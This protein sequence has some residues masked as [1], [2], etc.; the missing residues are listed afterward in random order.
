[1]ARINKLSKAIA[2]ILSGV[3]LFTGCAQRNDSSSIEASQ[4]PTSDNIIQTLP[5]LYNW[6]DVEFQYDSFSDQAFLSHIEDLVYAETVTSLNSEQ[7]FIENVSAIYI[8]KEYL[9]EV[10]YNSQSNIYFG[11]TLSELNE[12]F[13]GT[14]YIYTLDEDGTTT[15][16]EMVVVDSNVTGEILQNVAVGTGVILICITI[17]V[18]A[19]ALKADA[20][21][22]IFAAGA[23]D[24]ILDATFGSITA[25]IVKGIENGNVIS[26]LTAASEGFKI[27]AI[28]GTLEGTSLKALG[29]F[30]ASLG[31]LTMNEAARIQRESGY[32]LDV[33]KQLNNY[34]QYD[35][36]R[37]AGLTPKMVNGQTALVRSIDLNYVDKDGITNL[38]RMLSGRA[39]IDPATGKPYELHHIGQEVDSTLA[40]L[41]E[42]E[43][44]QNGNYTIWHNTDISS[45]VHT[46]DNNWDAQR[47]LFW[48]SLAKIMGG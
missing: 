7:Y 26:G 5:D 47:K 28:S 29:L 2:I 19:S 13:K 32:P 44:V 17:S 3:M 15:V 42:A 8:S 43:H 30:G 21:S 34:D 23:K 16:E 12:I 9:D 36:C 35:I 27:G 33:I 40:I 24:A 6:T 10:A 1:M 31:G 20:I 11:Y 14:K 18:V 25:G 37:R 4:P 22:V 48:K 46:K 41:T 39:A 45:E 38:Q